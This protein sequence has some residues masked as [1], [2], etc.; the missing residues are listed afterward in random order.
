[1][2]RGTTH[3]SS[4]WLLVGGLAIAALSPVAGLGAGIA[5]ASARPSAHPT[6]RATR[7]V[8]VFPG[9]SGGFGQAP[10]LSF[11]AGA[12]PKVLESKVLHAGSG[13]VVHKGDLLVANYLGQIWKGKVFDSSF[14]RHV[15]AGFVIGEGQVVPGWDKTLVGARVGSRMLLVIP[16]ADGYPTGNSAAG[17]KAGD[18]L[19]FVVDVIA[20]YGKGAHAPGHVAILMSDVGGVTVHGSVQ[21]APRISVAKGARTPAKQLTTVLARGSG[22]KVVPGLVAVQFALADWTGKVQESTWRTGSAYGATVGIPAQPSSLDSLVG[23]R[24]GSRVLIEIPKT[25]TGG[26]YVVVIDLVAQP[27]AAR[28]GK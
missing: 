2:R 19:A 12:A 18:T 9:V 27:P 21:S 20:T 4:R 26:P 8:R 6:H 25:A 16:P 5:S 28:L 11:P 10:K 13:P 1:M 7:P 14:T 15:A 23:L 3:L 17:I 22:P 24:I